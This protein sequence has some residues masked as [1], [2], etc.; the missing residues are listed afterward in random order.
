MGGGVGHQ[1]FRVDEDH[2]LVVGVPPYNA[3]EGLGREAHGHVGPVVMGVGGR[4]HGQL[5]GN[6]PLFH[7]GRIA[8]KGHGDGGV[9]PH[10]GDGPGG[11]GVAHLGAHGLQHRPDG[12]KGAAVPGL[13]A[14]VGKG[15]KLPVQ[16]DGDAGLGRLRGQGGDAGAQQGRRTGGRQDAPGESVHVHTSFSICL[17]HSTVL[18][19]PQGAERNF[20]KDLVIFGIIIAPPP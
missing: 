17:H 15:E 14:G 10:G 2:G 1:L 7:G 20:F 8:P 5:V 13:G 18:L 9:P 6:A 3:A 19:A 4:V 11:G 12:H 16:L